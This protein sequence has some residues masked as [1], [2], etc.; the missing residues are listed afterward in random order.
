MSIFLMNAPRP[1]EIYEKHN[2]KQRLIN[3]SLVTIALITLITIIALPADID[4]LIILLI[5]G[6]ILLTPVAYFIV[7]EIKGAKLKTKEEVK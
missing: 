5:L 7:W 3:L 6:A 4:E 2:A 1:R